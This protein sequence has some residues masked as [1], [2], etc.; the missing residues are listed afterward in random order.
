MTACWGQVHT[1]NIS[2]F[3]DRQEM[4]DTSS[5]HVATVFMNDLETDFLINKK[6][7]ILIID[8]FPINLIKKQKH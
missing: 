7:I 2:G 5:R 6:R 1:L 3:D 4:T 8:F